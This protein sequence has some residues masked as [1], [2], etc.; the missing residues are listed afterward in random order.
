MCSVSTIFKIMSLWSYTWINKP[1]LAASELLKLSLDSCEDLVVK[2]G[3][4]WE[5]SWAQLTTIFEEFQR[6]SL[7]VANLC[8]EHDS[9]K[10]HAL[11]KHMG[12]RKVRNNYISVR[13]TKNWG[14]NLACS[15]QTFMSGLN[16]FWI[17][18]CSWSVA[19]RESVVCLALSWFAWSEDWIFNRIDHL[20]NFSRLSFTSFPHVFKCMH[21]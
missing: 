7:I 21:C 11:V 16:T 9:K 3:Y 2:S 12:W 15:N 10:D 18:S 1:F 6:I 14:S 19:Q 13:N 5:K 4:R 8:A 20:C 17:S